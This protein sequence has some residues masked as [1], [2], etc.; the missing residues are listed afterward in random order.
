MLTRSAGRYELPSATNPLFSTEARR[1]GEV[2]FIKPESS[3]HSRTPLPRVNQMHFLKH[4]SVSPCLRGERT[5]LHV[6]PI[7]SHPHIRHDRHLQLVDVFHLVAHQLAH[8][9]HF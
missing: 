8:L 3:T 4:S 6:P 5:L 1:R 7:L 2:H 9:I